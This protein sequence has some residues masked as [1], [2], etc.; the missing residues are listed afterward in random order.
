MWHDGTKYI[1]SIFY[2]SEFLLFASLVCMFCM[3]ATWK[4]NGKVYSNG[5]HTFSKY[6]LC[7][8][9]DSMAYMII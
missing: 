9:H 7:G 5:A 3:N 2:L 4:Q 8:F 6:I 1:P